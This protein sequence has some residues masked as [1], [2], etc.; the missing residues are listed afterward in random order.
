MGSF[1]QRSAPPAGQWTTIGAI[2]GDGSIG[3]VN[4][5]VVNRDQVNQ[6][7]VSLASSA[8]AGAPASADYIEPPSLVLSA[9]AVLEETAFAVVPGE[10][11]QIFVSAAT[12]STRVHGR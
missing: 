12:V 8:G 9:G 1:V 5:R 4:I 2:P 10:V 6:I 3:T 7:T 11:I